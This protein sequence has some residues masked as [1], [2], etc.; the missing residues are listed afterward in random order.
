MESYATSLSRLHAKSVPSN[1]SK[2]IR[3]SKANRPLP[4]LPISRF[5]G[6]RTEDGMQ[7]FDQ[8]A[9]P[10]LEKADVILGRDKA[11]GQD[12]IVYG[13]EVM[14]RLEAVGAPERHKV[15]VVELDQNTELN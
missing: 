14:Q 8:T 4:A 3:M 12:F 6:Y 9:L 1:H 5:I 15:T 11:T 2:G 13:R 10:A 7:I